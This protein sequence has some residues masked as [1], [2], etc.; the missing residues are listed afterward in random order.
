MMA[1]LV[2]DIIPI[3]LL[4]PNIYFAQSDYEELVKEKTL[5]SHLFNT[6]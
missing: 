6:G 3:N 5:W 4:S 2:L 1:I